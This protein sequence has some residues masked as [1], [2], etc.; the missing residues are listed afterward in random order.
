MQV[1][2]QVCTM[3]IIKTFFSNRGT[4]S[5]VIQYRTTLYIH[6]T[7]MFILDVHMQTYMTP[8]QGRYY[9]LSQRHV[10][11]VQRYLIICISV[12]TNLLFAEHIVCIL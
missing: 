5:K 6:S 9:Y 1:C 12:H 4:L 7:H 3:Y 2:V 11:Y 10:E 8:I